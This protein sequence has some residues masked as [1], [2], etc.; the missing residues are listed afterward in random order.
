LHP[1]QERERLL[2]RAE[3]YV[4][5]AARRLVGRARLTR[6]DVADLE[7]ELR[8]GLW[9]RLHLYDARRG[10]EDA[11]LKVIVNRLASRLTRRSRA[12][13]RDVR[14]EVSLIDPEEVTDPAGRR[15]EEE[16]DARLDVTDALARLSC[17]LAH[18]AE[19]L[20]TES[21]TSAAKTLG[22]TRHAAR[23]RARRLL[24][25]LHQAGLDAYLRNSP[26]ARERLG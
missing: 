5:A 25:H 16:V 12:A 26:P 24:A 3:P 1:Y 9:S 13:K 14:R 6:S 2:A 23:G 7:Q 21:L 10:D 4:R 20:P 11:F 18:L 22:L 17:E 15:T 8:L 19:L